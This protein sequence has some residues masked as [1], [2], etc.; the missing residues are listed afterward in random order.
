M[1]LNSQ[2]GQVLSKGCVREVQGG[3]AP[4]TQMDASGK[5]LSF[6]CE[7]DVSD[8]GT[9]FLIIAVNTMIAF[10]I[11]GHEEM[12]FINRLKVKCTPGSP[13]LR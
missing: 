3:T 1:G 7:L 8:A 5:R 6:T 12:K 4:M 9:K 13:P 10:A 2:T 11:T